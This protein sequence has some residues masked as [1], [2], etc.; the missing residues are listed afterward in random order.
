MPLRHRQRLIAS[1][2]LAVIACGG[3]PQAPAYPEVDPEF[4]AKNATAPGVRVDPPPALTLQPGDT[5]SIRIASTETQE[6]TGLVIDGVGN[7]HIPL[8]G[9]V[10]VGGVGLTAAEERLQAALQRHDRLVQ[11]TVQM[12]G[13][14]GQRA[15]VL[16]AVT[17]Q[18]PVELIPGA[19]ITDVVA[20]AGGPIAAATGP[21]PVLV[22]TLA[23][24][25]LM[26][27]GKVVPVDM[28][29]A[30]RGDPLHN[31]Y[32]HAGDHIYVPPSV[33]AN[34]SMLGQVG[35]PQVFPHREGI[36]LTE[37]L[38]IAGGVTT[39][40]DKGDIRVIRGTLREPHVYR[41]SLSDL[42]DGDTHDVMLRPGDIIFV[43]DHAIEDFNEVMG[44]IAPALSLGLSSLAL[45][46]SLE[47]R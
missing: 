41:A 22:A 27:T 16:G 45:G 8:A 25:V 23:D 38:A 46:I 1:C 20:G 29:K 34:I 42:V 18:G 37:A 9:D 24:A 47:S 28:R 39:G 26:R 44:V 14:A 4:E 13:R 3:F 43:T 32:V 31:V 35:A 10:H 5:I 36:R 2:L 33:G 17:R 40:A 12:T 11:V 15:T 30:L 6:H 21:N 7:V 19:R